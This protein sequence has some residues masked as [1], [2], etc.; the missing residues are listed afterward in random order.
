MSTAMTGGDRDGKCDDVVEGPGGR[1]IDILTPEDQYHFYSMSTLYP[2][3]FVTATIRRGGGRRVCGLCSFDKS[4]ES[5]TVSTRYPR[6]GVWCTADDR[7]C[8]RSQDINICPAL[9]VQQPCARGD[10]GSLIMISGSWHRY[11]CVYAVR[12]TIIMV[13]VGLARMRSERVLVLR[14][15]HLLYST[16]FRSRCNYRKTLIAPSVPT[17]NDSDNE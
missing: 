2:R 7:C 10:I 15:S 8:A 14:N 1:I 13:T 6:N 4:R 12:M 3:G 9:E 11:Y 17:S 16:S 5:C